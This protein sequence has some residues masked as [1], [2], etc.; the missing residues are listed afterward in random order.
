MRGYR[1]DAELLAAF[2][3]CRGL[4]SLSPDAEGRFQAVCE[5]FAIEFPT[6]TVA[7]AMAH[8]RAGRLTWEQVHNLFYR[9]LQSAMADDE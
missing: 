5:A 1:S 6:D 7:R 8:A 4:E 9:A 2:A 3:E